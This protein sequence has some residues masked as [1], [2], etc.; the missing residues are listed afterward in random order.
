M[1]RTMN[2]LSEFMSLILGK[3]SVT[4]GSSW[5]QKKILRDRYYRKKQN[6]LHEK[7]PIINYYKS[8]QQY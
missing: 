8:N 4:G 2:H 1:K 3:R 5:I 6:G 7:K